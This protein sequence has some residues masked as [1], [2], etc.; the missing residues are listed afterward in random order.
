MK[1]ICK[2][3]QEHL[4]WVD[5]VKGI[6][7]LLVALFH[8]YMNTS[9]S[10]YADSIQLALFFFISGY[11]F[12]NQP[13]KKLLKRRFFSLIVPYFTFSFISFLYYYFIESRFRNISITILEGIKG[14]CLGDYLTLVIFNAPLWFLPCLF[15]LTLIFCLLNKIHYI[16]PYIMALIFIS[17]YLI[18]D[19]PSLYFALDKTIKYFCFFVV[20]NF[21][22]KKEFHKYV[23]KW[24]SLLLGIIAFIIHLIILIYLKHNV[25]WFISGFLGIFYICLLCINI[26]N[27]KGIQRVIVP[28]GRN[29]LIILCVHGPIYRIIVFLLASILNVEITIV[30]QNILYS[31]LVLLITMSISLCFAWVINNYIPFIIGKKYGRRKENEKN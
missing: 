8:I 28:I 10:N 12:Y 25:F 21:F 20:G 5:L 31:I 15:T 30:R 14:I 22:R 27:R 29:S 13:I 1:S 3:E 16:V 4:I 18:F 23:G 9:F 26:E 6:G 2:T 24:V 17:A 11:L 19:I 7:I